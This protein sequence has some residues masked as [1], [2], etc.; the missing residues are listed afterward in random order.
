MDA[1][2]KFLEKYSLKSDMINLLLGIILIVSLVIIYKYPNNQ[3]C[4]LTACI[5]GGLINVTY[6]LKL[7]KD[8]KKMTTGMPFLMM[9]IIVIVLGFVIISMM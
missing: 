5:S 1:F 8:P 9:G 6:G 2:R 7:M 3:M 4:I